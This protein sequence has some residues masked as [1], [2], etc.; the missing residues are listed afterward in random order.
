MY[1]TWYGKMWNPGINT[2]L[3]DL[4]TARKSVDE[5]CA[6]ME[7]EAKA[8][9]DDDSITELTRMLARAAGREPRGAW[10]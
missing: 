1:N 4:L 5:F 6:G 10:R 8:V 9:R 2:Q 3:G 7:A